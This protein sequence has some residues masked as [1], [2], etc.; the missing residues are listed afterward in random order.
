MQLPT[1][2]MTTEAWK[3]I[4]PRPVELD[5]LRFTQ[6]GVYIRA[7]LDVHHGRHEPFTG[8]PYPHIVDYAGHLYIEDGNTRCLHATVTGKRTIMARVLHAD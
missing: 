2:G 6:Q 4:Q 5:K 8:D 1:E 7:L 3:Q